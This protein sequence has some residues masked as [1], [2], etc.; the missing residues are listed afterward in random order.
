MSLSVERSSLARRMQWPTLHLHHHHRLQSAE[1]DINWRRLCRHQ[2]ATPIPT[3]TTMLPMDEQ[4][5]TRE[6]QLFVCA[7]GVDQTA[8]TSSELTTSING[9]SSWS[10]MTTTIT[11]LK[12]RRALMTSELRHHRRVEH[13]IIS[14]CPHD[15]VSMISVAVSSLN[16]MMD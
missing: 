9:S 2:A 7:P 1:L 10:A 13:H 3:S 16:S 8:V 6:C 15:D 11:S 5:R 14:S 4:S 12:G